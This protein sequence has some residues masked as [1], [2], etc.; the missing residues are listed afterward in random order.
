MHHRRKKQRPSPYL[1]AMQKYLKMFNS[2]TPSEIV[3]YCD[4]GYGRPCCHD[5]ADCI[6]KCQSAS[7]VTFLCRRPKPAT[8]KEWTR[9]RVNCCWIVIGCICPDLLGQAVREMVPNMLQSNADNVA[10]LAA[11][12][13]GALGA[14]DGDRERVQRSRLQFAIDFSQT[15]S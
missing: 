7:N 11:G 2:P 5:I 6:A 1:R 15:K 9:V 13:A 10:D 3:H 4:G 12:A 14:H 8:M